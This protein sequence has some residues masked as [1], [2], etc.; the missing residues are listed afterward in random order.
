MKYSYNNIIAY[1]TNNENIMN[2]IIVSSYVI[3]H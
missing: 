1:I 2:N 3:K